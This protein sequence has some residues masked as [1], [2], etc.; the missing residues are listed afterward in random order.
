[1][2]AQT[3]LAPVN[4]ESWAMYFYGLLVLNSAGLASRAA[5]PTLNQ[6]P[7]PLSLSEREIMSR[8]SQMDEIQNWER[9]R[10]RSHLIGM[11]CSRMGRWW[12]G[13]DVGHTRVRHGLGGEYRAP[14]L[15]EACPAQAPLLERG[16][17]STVAEGGSCDGSGRWRRIRLKITV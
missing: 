5:P 7:L 2:E 15:K 14:P 9:Q 1:M 10:T 16:H 3:P 12:G 11:H 4:L 6:E 8:N 13:S 17:A